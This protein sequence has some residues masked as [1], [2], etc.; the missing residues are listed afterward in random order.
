MLGLLVQFQMMPIA[1]ESVV[2]AAHPA[3]D[4]ARIC[5]NIVLL[6]LP[7]AVAAAADAGG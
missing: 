2:A 4:A 3:A 6:L 1:V 5:G 7:P